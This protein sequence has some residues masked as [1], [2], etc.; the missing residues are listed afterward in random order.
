MRVGLGCPVVLVSAGESPNTKCGKCSES[1]G[2]HVED[3]GYVSGGGEERG[4]WKV[5][6]FYRMHRDGEMVL[7]GGQKFFTAVDN[8]KLGLPFGG[9]FSILL[10]MVSRE[11]RQERRARERQRQKNGDEIQGNVPKRL[12]NRRIAPFVLSA[13]VGMIVA[14]VGMKFLLPVPKK[15][16]AKKKEIYVHVPRFS[17]SEKTYG[18]I[19]E[20]APEEVP[21]AD[22]AELNLLC[23]S[24]LPGTDGIDIGK[25]MKQLDLLTEMVRS[26]TLRNLG[27][28]QR[29]PAEY[30]NSQAYYKMGM[31]ITVVRQDYKAKYNPNLIVP[32]SIG[33]S[34]GGDFF[35]NGADVF[36]Q[37]L[38]SDRRMGTCSSM[39]V[40]YV[41]IGRRLGYPVHLVATKGHLFCRWEDGKERMNFEGTGEGIS[42]HPDSYYQNWPL[43][44]TKHEVKNSTFL[45]NLN[46]QQELAVFL[47]NR[48]D[49]LIASG[50]HAE[51][52]IAVSQAFRLVQKCGG[53][54]GIVE[55]MASRPVIPDIV[56]RKRFER[57]PKNSY[58]ENP[59]F[60]PV[61]IPPEPRVKIL[62]PFLPKTPQ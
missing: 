43:P 37:G 6:G 61:P 62:N 46:P 2:V 60:P 32:P 54:T 40:L 51:A 41:A 19:L 29:N 36:L 1:H 24:G 57:M 30:R 53:L 59:C 39:P 25:C 26:E 4:L 3:D 14:L 22:V 49:C 38:L 11:T 18:N 56:Y 35:K 15:E 50:R 23:G 16:Q 34:Q 13:L 31:L 8:R 20:L 33:D 10:T 55:Q 52:L 58:P 7:P 28:W 42:I 5:G 45:K 47:S 48:A 27:R 44:L 21:A 12:R 17:L 9:F